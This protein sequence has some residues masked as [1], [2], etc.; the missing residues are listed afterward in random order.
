[1]RNRIVAIGKRVNIKK[2]HITGLAMMFDLFVDIVK[3]K[4][5]KIHAVSLNS[6]VDKNVKIGTVSFLRVIEYVWIITKCL[7]IIAFNPK[8]ILYINPVTTKAGMLRDALLVK[9]AKFW[10][11][12]ILMQQFGATFRSFYDSLSPRLRCVLGN[13]YN[14]SDIIIV[15]GE[16]AKEQLEFLKDKNKIISIPNGLPEKNNVVQ[17]IGKKYNKKFAFQL[18]YLS[19]LIE[20][21]GYRDVLKAV[22]IL[23]NERTLNV[24]LIIAGKFLSVVDDITFP[25]ATE[26]EKEFHNFI[27]SKNLKEIIH[28]YPGLYN[29]DKAHYFQK[30]NVFLLPS[31]YIFEG[32]PTAI[33]EA[34]SY[35][36]V[37]IVTNYR[38]IPEMVNESCGIF[39][40][41]QNPYEIA[42]AI[43]M[44]MNNEEEYESL[45]QNAVDMFLNNF[46]Q[47][48]YAGKILDILHTYFN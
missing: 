40:N 2:N 41:K 37:P 44:L 10:G 9:F 43:E 11:Y 12:K 35:G 5:Y 24:E 17:L 31:Y 20:S 19:N 15:E 16:F 30:S 46:T 32:Q 33:L 13:A 21:K 23:V 1:M 6:K 3:N 25:S 38:L 48:I 27:K 7:V 42:D 39:V 45:S 34:L 47:K 8:S 36:S 18:F 14:S 28:Y 4:G 22:D 29:G 26:A